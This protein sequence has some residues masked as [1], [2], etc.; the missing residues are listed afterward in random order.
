M[1]W[2]K[3]KVNVYMKPLMVDLLKDKPNNSLDFMI[4][5]LQTNGKKIEKNQKIKEG[6]A[7]DEEVEQKEVEHLPQSD[8]EKDD[9]IE[10]ANIPKMEAKKSIMKKKLAIS[11]EAYGEYNQL[12]NFEPRVVPKTEEQLQQ[13]RETLKSSFTFKALEERSLQIVIQAMAILELAAGDKAITQGDDGQDL[14][15]LSSGKLRCTRKNK[16]SAEEVFLKNYEPGEVFGELSLLYNVPRAAT[17]VAT[18]ASVCFSL[19]RDTFNH[20]VKN[21]AMKQREKY[22]AFLNKIEILQELEPYERSK[23]CDCLE[24]ETFK[25]GEF[26]IKQGQDGDKFYLIQEGTADAVQTNEAGVESKV[27]EFKENDYF[28]E[29]ALVND[30]KRKASIRATSDSLVVTSL[31]KNAF[32]RL[33]GPLEK[34]LMRKASKY[35]LAIQPNKVAI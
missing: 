17:I 4:F 22:D 31:S 2:L 15:I 25:K 13:I 35:D 21:A 1:D 26:V 27:Y 3:T 10:E 6:L 29:L 14:Y 33:L 5:W 8:S 18:E 9:E 23:L 24:T 32:K 20:I 34:I 19:D 7:I 16:D 12:G 11:A 28:G 30:D